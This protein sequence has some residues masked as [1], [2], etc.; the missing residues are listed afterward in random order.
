MLGCG[1]RYIGPDLCVTKCSKLFKAR[2]D[3]AR[4]LTAVVGYNPFETMLII[5]RRDNH[6]QTQ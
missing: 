4:F 3:A 2:F 6:L 5:V 1:V